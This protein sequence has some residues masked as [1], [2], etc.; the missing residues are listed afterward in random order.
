METGVYRWGQLLERWPRAEILLAIDEKSLVKLRHGW[1]ATA[2]ANQAVV[3]A[4]QA[5]GLLSCASALRLHGVWVPPT[6]HV[7]IRGNSN[8]ARNHPAWCRQFG[9]QP[10]EHD[11]VDDLPTALAHATRCLSA[12]DLVV[13]CDSLLNKRLLTETDINDVLRDAPRTVRATLGRVDGRAESG[14]ESMVR[15]RLAAPHLQIRPQVT[16]LGV[17]RV[18][19]LV[20]RSLIIEVDN[21]EYHSS[22]SAFENDRM[23]DLRAQSLGYRMIRLSYTQVVYQWPEVHA[24][25]EQLVHR[26][27]HRRPLPTTAAQPDRTV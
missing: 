11:A 12:E 3:A 4:V 14:T 18:D 13:V 20:G 16:I 15:L 26:A 27:E 10:A 19:L 7:H 17:G 21:E 25:I 1:Y 22:S 9:R 2:N 5:G 8:T 24:L 6:D 23:R